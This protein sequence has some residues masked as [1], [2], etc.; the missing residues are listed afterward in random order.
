MKTDLDAFELSISLTEILL[1]TTL[2]F[3]GS[4]MHEYI[5]SVKKYHIKN[6]TSISINISLTVIIDVIICISINQLIL[7]ISPRLVLLPP[8]I[9]GL[10]GKQ[11]VDSLTSL[12]ATSRI[13]AFI[14]SLLG[15]G[16]GSSSLPDPDNNGEESNENEKKE[17]PTKSVKK[18]ESKEEKIKNFEIHSEKLLNAM[19]NLIVKYLQ[20]DIKDKDF[21]IIYKVIK[22]NVKAIKIRIQDNSIVSVDEALRVSE[23]VKNED[24][25]DK[26]YTDIMEKAV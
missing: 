10:V 7:D 8:L 11:L 15:M 21:I 16:D 23:I 4:L 12:K 25:L 2:S 26:I 3:I 20:N 17:Q 1:M 22:V 9:I 14:F 24:Y 19:N 18:E 5:V 13:I 6:L